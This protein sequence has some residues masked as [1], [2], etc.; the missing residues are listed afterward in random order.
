MIKFIFSEQA[1]NEYVYWHRHDKKILRRINI[2]LKDI[3]NKNYSGVGNPEPLE[4]FLS[5]LWSRRIDD[6]NRLVY[7]IPE[8]AGEKDIEILQC[9][10]HYKE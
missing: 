7:R 4:S 2:L 9:R 3:Q 10:G 1:W 5:G 6:T 8:F